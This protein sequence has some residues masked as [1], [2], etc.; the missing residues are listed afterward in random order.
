MTPGNQTVRIIKIVGMIFLGLIIVV[1]VTGLIYQSIGSVQDAE[2]RRAPPG[3]LIDVNGEKLHIDCRGSGANTLVLEAGGLS[4]SANWALIQPLLAR[5]HRVCSYDRPGLGWSENAEP[6]ESLSAWRGTLFTLLQNAGEEGPYVLIGHSLGG[7]LI[8]EY[9]A[10]DRSNISGLIFIDSGPPG[11]YSSMSKKMREHFEA[12]E[13]SSRMMPTLARFGFL[14]FTFRDLNLGDDFPNN[15]NEAIK[16]FFANVRHID[17]GAREFR[18]AND[19]ENAGQNL[20]QT[21]IPILAIIGRYDHNDVEG[22]VELGMAYHRELADLSVQNG[23]FLNIEGAS[24]AD[25]LG[26]EPYADQVVTAIDAF[27]AGTD[28][29]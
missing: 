27:I 25:L 10:Q 6:A 7:A 17:I 29:D 2:I 19:I 26:T 5:Q 18:L 1:P 20:S 23:R 3:R 4:F 11:P 28:E 14:R 12:A 24:H 8:R 22:H 16:A 13:Q 21:T 9:A 15:E